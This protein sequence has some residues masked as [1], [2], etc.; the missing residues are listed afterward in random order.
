MNR[1]PLDDYPETMPSR[2]HEEID[3]RPMPLSA[4]PSS[5]SGWML[6]GIVVTLALAVAWVA[7]GR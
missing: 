3:M 7:A 2:L 6:V 4:E 5:K 1:A